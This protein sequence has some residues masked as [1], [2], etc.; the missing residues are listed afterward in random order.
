MEPV[1]VYRASRG[2]NNASKGVTTR[3]VHIEKRLIPRW[4]AV[5]EV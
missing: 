3:L 4:V 5:I 1:K 2:N